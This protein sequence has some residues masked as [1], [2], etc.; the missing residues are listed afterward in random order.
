MP[1][2]T[3]D[4]VQYNLS[5]PNDVPSS[6]NRIG[7]VEVT[8]MP[9]VVAG[10]DPNARVATSVPTSSSIQ[11]PVDTRFQNLLGQTGQQAV[12]PGLPFGTAVQGA[13]VQTI[14][15]G[16][17]QTAP[18]INAPQQVTQQ[19]ID[20]DAFVSDIPQEQLAAQVQGATA[21]EVE[22]I[23][24]ETTA[25]LGQINAQ[26]LIDD[27]QGTLS[28]GAL[29][30]AQTEA[31]D[32]KATVQFQLGELYKSLDDDTQLPPWAAPAARYLFWKI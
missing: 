28:S 32:E 17:V 15:P 3:R 10:G 18:L 12:S 8:P 7:P 22:P 24:A 4:G 21:R 14:A 20:P 2:V 26:D 5:G 19:T 9:Q 29:A 23:A 30:Q 31:L 6:G 11:Q 27:V 13:Q 25:V 1:I 16:E